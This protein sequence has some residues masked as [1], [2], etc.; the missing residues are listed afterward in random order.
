MDPNSDKPKLDEI[1]IMGYSI[2][3]SRY[4]YTE[5]VHFNHTSFLANWTNVVSTELYDH[6]IDP[7]ENLNLIGRPEM[8]YITDLLRKELILGWRYA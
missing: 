3:T 1:N 5:W 8:K 2:R 7:N 4:R 6:L